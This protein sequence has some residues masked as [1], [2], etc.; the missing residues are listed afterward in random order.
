MLV[1]KRTTG[2]RIRI[3]GPDGVANWI[4]LS[5][6]SHGTAR[7]GFEFADSYNIAREEVIVRPGVNHDG[8]PDKI[9]GAPSDGWI[10]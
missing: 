5:G 1:L 9:D 3:T 4:T 10:K 2:Q 8:G 6:T 7:I